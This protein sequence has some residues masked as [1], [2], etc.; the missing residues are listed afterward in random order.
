[1]YNRILIPTDGSETA[2][3]GVEHGL[4]LA[5][6]LNIPVTIVT[7][8]VP[9]S[10]LALESVVQGEA[11]DSYNEAVQE[12]VK[13]LEKRVREQAAKAAV[14]IEFVSEF[15][16]SPAAAILETAHARKCDVIVIAS[17]GRRGI[18]RLMLGSQ[19]AEVIANSTIPVLIVK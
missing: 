10:G 13:G 11:F 6:A 16:V 12:E 7:V 4:A 17:H 19:T 15:N 5:Q 18:R 3:K 2:A 9:L 1:M 14:P 8:T